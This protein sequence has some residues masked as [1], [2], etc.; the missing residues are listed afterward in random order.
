M[1]STGVEAP[2]TDGEAAGQ[3]TRAD[4]PTGAAARDEAQQKLGRFHIRQRLGSGSFGAVY[5]AHDPVLDR[6]VALKVPR[7]SAL[8][9]PEARARFLREP[10]AAAQLRHPNIVPV[11]DAGSEG[12]RY[13]IA[14]AFIQGHTLEQVISERRPDFREAAKVVRE[15]ALA[16]DYA[17]RMG[18]VHRDV[19]PANIMIDDRGQALLMDFG[20]ARL[21]RMEEKLTQDGAVMGTPAYLPPEQA[22]RSL[23]EVGPVSDQY[24]LGVVF[25]EL[26]CGER[27][28]Q[29]TPA[30][31]IYNAVH[32]AAKSPRTVNRH[33]PR[34][35]ETICLKAMAKDPRKRYQDCAQLAEDLRRWLDDEPIHARRMGFGE[36]AARWARRNPLAAT[37]LAAMASALVA[38]TV[39][40]QTRP[41]YW[42][43]RVAPADARVILDG[44]RVELVE[45]RG[46]VKTA[47]GRKQ[48]RAWAFDHVEHAQ[49]VLLVRGRANTVVTHIDL[50]SVFGYVQADSSPQGVL[51]EIV[52]PTGAVLQ[53]G[54]TPM[55]SPP[56]PAS[57]YT[58]RYS[59]DAYVTVERPVSVP[60]GFQTV[61]V[62]AP[63]LELAVEG[64]QSFE[65]LNL[66][67]Q[68]V[69]EKLDEVANLE[70]VS[71][72]LA[73]VFDYFKSHHGLRLQLDVRALEDVGISSDVPVTIN[74]QDV[75]L[76]AA[77]RL[78]LR[79][80]DLTYV[81]EPVGPIGSGQY[82]L[83]VTTSEEIEQRL[84]SVLHPVGDLVDIDT[85][86]LEHSI[87]Q[88][89]A[90]ASWDMVGG[91][92]S[93]EYLAEVKA[94]VVVHTWHVQL[95][96]H[97]FLDDMR[98]TRAANQQLVERERNRL[99]NDTEDAGNRSC[100]RLAILR[101]KLQEKLG[102][103]VDLSFTEAPLADVVRELKAS[104]DI[105]IQFDDRALDDVGIAR[106][107]P[108]TLN[109]NNVSLEAAL[110]RMLSELDLTYVPEPTGPLTSAQFLLLVTTLRE[111]EQRLVH[112]VHPIKDLLG[113]EGALAQPVVD[114]I[115]ETVKPNSW[116]SAS[117]PGSI[118]V[119]PQVGALVVNQTWETQL[120]IY[121]LL[122]DLR[123]ARTRMGSPPPADRNSQGQ[124]ASVPGSFRFGAAHFVANAAK[125]YQSQSAKVLGLPVEITNSINMK[126]VL[127]PADEAADGSIQ[128]STSPDHGDRTSPFY[129]GACEVTVGQFKE[130]MS[131]TSYQTD[132]E[133][134][135][136]VRPGESKAT[137]GSARPKGNP[138]RTWRNPGFEQSDSQ[139]VCIV[140]FADAVAFCDWLSQ[141]EKR[142]YR[143]P[144]ELEW[145]W[146]CRAGTATSYY[147]GESPATLTNHAWYADNSDTTTHPVGLLWPNPWSLFDMYGNVAEMCT[148]SGEERSQDK[149]TDSASPRD[150]PVVLR[151]GS[152]HSRPADC[153]TIS[154]YDC[155]G[156]YLTNGFRVVCEIS[157]EAKT[158]ER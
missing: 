108:V 133:K 140:S 146:A 6:E 63:T 83:M 56:I 95:K 102:Q 81:P 67:R 79:E 53:R 43:V 26:L 130:F 125:R 123:Q 40:W 15:L 82:L 127:I 89:I 107:T 85:G 84:I 21:E 37:I 4:P 58:L 12:E 51:V 151:G 137:D 118:A 60:N 34:D 96:V 10:K 157:E 17:H 3:D 68:K 150:H 62:E 135:A 69:Q 47:P 147:F 120:A 144:T 110:D 16:L 155:L 104:Y 45:G 13:Y 156:Y 119:V 8:E 121:D 100:Q 101:Q 7:E 98:L 106:D 72:P 14:S 71:T 97:D 128:L 154:R 138:I 44:Q 24:S 1:S 92:G 31:L 87:V 158:D 152:Y 41:A 59:K 36:R 30:V 39:Y 38:G 112:V 46:L 64:V 33:I 116:I 122:N 141:R 66:L 109:V 48:I 113:W 25:Y 75:S 134:G 54:T 61:V 91:P 22:D 35:L 99:A 115:V 18:V 74:L 153:T 29:G 129:L 94:I 80:L 145:Q 131:E 32:L 88:T 105:E 78:M 93:V 2:V 126:L 23:G 124:P 55:H 139:P 86:M 77:L 132:A 50:R 117:G 20:L 148:S 149:P 103:K 114:C 136:A 49:E 70:F 9:R 65:R 142:R 27:P 111:S 19:K 28:F 143:L 57:D 52:G 90:P 11:F 76:G 5:R 42:D 73:D